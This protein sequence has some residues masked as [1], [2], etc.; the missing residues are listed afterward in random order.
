[1]TARSKDIWDRVE[2]FGIAPVL[3]A[4]V[5]WTVGQSHERF[6]AAQMDATKAIVSQLEA[7]GRA[8]ERIEAV[9]S[10]QSEVLAELCKKVQADK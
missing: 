6:I 5:L 1:M 10:R 7:Q 2:R 4:A 9:Q 3:L 8:I